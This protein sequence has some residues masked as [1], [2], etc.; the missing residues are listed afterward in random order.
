MGQSCSKKKCGFTRSK[1]LSPTWQGDFRYGDSIPKFFWSSLGSHGEL[2]WE[3]LICLLE[4]RPSKCR[5][6][7]AQDMR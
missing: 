6:Q 7:L 4:G 3:Q 1:E 5:K 2:R